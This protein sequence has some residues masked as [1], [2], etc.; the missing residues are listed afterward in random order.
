MDPQAV[1]H[2][3]LK[4]VG[5]RHVI[6]IELDAQSGEVI[7]VSGDRDAIRRTCSILLDGFE[8][9]TRVDEPT[10]EVERPPLPGRGRALTDQ[11]VRDRA[12]PSSILAAIRRE[13]ELSSSTA[14]RPND[15]ECERELHSASS[16]VTSTRTWERELPG[17]VEPHDR[18]A[19]ERDPSDHCPPLD[20]RSGD[21]G[22]VAGSG[23]AVGA[24]NHVADDPADFTS[25]SGTPASDSRDA[26]PPQSPSE[27]TLARGLSGNASFAN[28]RMKSDSKGRRDRSSRLSRSTP[29]PFEIVEE[30]IRLPPLPKAE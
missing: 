11:E 27:D 16:D 7:S 3:N 15:H 9:R 17:L 18:T 14:L 26:F 6:S 2:P 22:N 5:S 20:A 12:R 30:A 8:D 4:L 28:D 19:F 24:P 10:A 21:N 13:R 23:P 1:S 29:N 25:A